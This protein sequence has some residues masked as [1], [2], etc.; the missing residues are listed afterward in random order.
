MGP[1]SY[2]RQAPPKAR[3]KADP[4]ALEQAG[5]GHAARAAG[6]VPRHLWTRKK[7]LKLWR[8]PPLHPGTSPFL[9]PGLSLQF[10]KMELPSQQVGVGVGCS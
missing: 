6:R 2:G 10:W 4:T 5:G 8:S 3:E 1:A 7:G 9:P